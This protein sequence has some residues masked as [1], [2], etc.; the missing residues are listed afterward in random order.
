MVLSSNPVLTISFGE[1]TT[2]DESKIN[3]TDT[4]DLLQAL[5]VAIVLGAEIPALAG[6]Y[7]WEVKY[8]D[9]SLREDN[10]FSLGK[11]QS[12]KACEFAL[13]NWI[14]NEWT[15]T[16]STPWHEVTSMLAPKAQQDKMLAIR[17]STNPIKAYLESHT[18]EE[19]IDWYFS[20]TYDRYEIERYTVSSEPEPTLG[21]ARKQ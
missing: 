20:R 17:S 12:K 2:M 10:V 6:S 11:F 8:F 18:D 14:I 3:R 15:E 13:V 21:L 19:I 9:N 7:F 5:A 4:E 16:G 1:E